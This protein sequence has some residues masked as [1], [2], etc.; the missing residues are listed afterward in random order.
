M[1]KAP[2]YPIVYLRGY[3]GTQGE[4]EDTVAD[5]YMGFNTGSTKLRQQWD[6]EVARHIFESPL[7]RLMKDFG[8]RDTYSEGEELSG[9]G[10]VPW[11]TVWI[12]RYYEP[13]SSELGEG[14]RPEMEAYADGLGVF[15]RELREKICGSDTAAKNA[16]KVY[17]VAHSMGGLV[18]RCWLQNRRGRESDPVQVEKLFTYGTPHRGIDFRLVGNLPSWARFNNTEN[19][20]ESRMR[21]YLDLET[22]EPVNSLA[23]ALPED[24]SFSLVGTNS[25]DYTVA[26]GLSSAAV[27][28]MSDGLVQIRNAYING[29]PRAFVHRAHS[30][31]YGL[32]NSEEGYQ[33]L[34]RF[35]FGDVRIDGRLRVSGV[36]LPDRV[37]REKDRGKEVRAS[38]HIEVSVNARDTRWYLHRRTVDEESAIHA[39]YDDMVKAG[40]PVHLF[41][42]YLAKHAIG[43]GSYMGYSVT[44]GV[45]VP[46]Y[47]VDNRFFFDDHFEGAYIFRDKLNMLLRPNEEGL[48]ARFGWDS[49]ASNGT[50]TTVEQPMNANRAWRIEI[51]VKKASAPGIEA[52]LE[53]DIADVSPT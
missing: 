28:P 45:L 20:S 49:S 46:E 26:G 15:L 10:A 53:L 41:S 7:I 51:P 4:V 37:Q 22:D 16:F 34:S 24:R 8:Y 14:R 38:Y 32:V 13:V 1:S 23:G 48:K 19:F 36:S 39:R 50:D 31:H 6:R 9:E 18:A 40:K 44:L 5:P 12:Y 11:K 27:G 21:E 25:K 29:G 47:R 17:L 43:R 33:N 52:V 42:Q 35:F 30:G 2:W 3:A